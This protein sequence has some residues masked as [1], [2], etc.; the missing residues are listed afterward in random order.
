MNNATKTTLERPTEL[1]DRSLNESTGLNVKARKTINYWTLGTHALQKCEYYGLLALL[2]KMGCGKSQTLNI[3]GNF[4]RNPVRISLRGTTLP[5]LR[6]RLVLAKDSTAIIE[7]A[8]DAW[9]D[10]SGS[11]ERLLSDRYSRS[12]AETAFKIQREVGENGK[13]GTRWQGVSAKYFGASVLHR[14]IGFRDGAL[15]GR[16]ITVRF[17]PNNDRQ[18][19]EFSATDPWNK[20]GHELIA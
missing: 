20:K 2:G 10:P 5:M 9:H 1:M 3:V 16:T 12:S 13:G 17:R 8:D 19:R 6:D 11:F 18:Y 15:D 4:A 14:R 7:E